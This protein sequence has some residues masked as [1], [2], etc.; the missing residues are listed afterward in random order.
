MLQLNSF[1]SL[2]KCLIKVK[3]NF[4][5]MKK[6][7]FLRQSTNEEKNSFKLN[8]QMPLIVQSVSKGVQLKIVL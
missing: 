7:E 6:K 3:F 4:L 2:Q 8:R 1:F 5:N